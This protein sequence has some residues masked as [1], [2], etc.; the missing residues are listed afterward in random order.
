MKIELRLSWRERLVVTGAD[1]PVCAHAGEDVT[2]SCSVDTHVNVTELQ[3]KWIKTDDDGDILVLLYD[4]G[5]NRPESQDERYSRRAEFY[6]EEIPKGNFSVKLRK[7][8][9]EDKGEFRCEVHSDTDSASTTARIAA[10]GYSSLHWLIL[11]L[12][13]T[14]T[15][16]VLLTGA[17][18][19]GHYI[20]KSKSKQALLSHW[21]HV[22]VPPIMVSS[23]FILW[24]VTEGSTEEAAICTVISLLNILVLFNMNPY[25]LYPGL[26]LRIIYLARTI[27]STII[28]M[29]VCTAPVIEFLKR[30]STTTAGKVTLGVF[31]GAFI[32]MMI[33]MAFIQFIFFRYIYSLSWR[34]T[35]GKLKKTQ[36][37]ISV[38]LIIMVLV[39]I[40]VGVFLA[41]HFSG[42]AET[43]EFLTIFSVSM[44][45]L[46]IPFVGLVILLILYLRSPAEIKERVFL[47]IF[48]LFRS[49]NMM[50]N[51]QILTFY[52]Q[53]IAWMQV[54]FLLGYF[55]PIAVASLGMCAC[56]IA[57]IF[58]HSF[59]HFYLA[60]KILLGIFF[61]LH[62][63][64][65]F[66]YL[67]LILENDK[68]RPAKMCEF[69]FIYIL[70]V[71]N[72]VRSCRTEYLA[73][74]RKYV[75]F[76]G[77][78]G[79]PLVNS[80]A[81]AVALKFK[82][83]TGKPPLDL[84]LIVLISGSVFLFSWLVIQM[85][86]NYLAR[87]V[88]IKEAFT[89]IKDPEPDQPELIQERLL[90]LRHTDEC[91]WE[92]QAYRALWR[93]TRPHCHTMRKVLKHM[94]H[95]QA[96][97]SCQV[98][99][100]ASTCRIISH[101][102]NCTE[103][104]CPICL[105]LKNEGY[106]WHYNEMDDWSDSSDSCVSNA[107]EGSRDNEETVALSPTDPNGPNTE[108]VNRGTR[109]L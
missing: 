56:F 61:I 16:A 102:E 38:F 98:K 77:A 103:H 85:Y 10:L 5:E 55:V 69:L 6:T 48:G 18:S 32:L 96:G 31:V 23:A 22:T 11:G 12:C 9:T 84:R 62:L 43:R 58:L 99:H 24:G 72:N 1:E 70:T 27:G 80:V 101:S 93:C 20:R 82:A 47:R 39:T 81:L 26:Q 78:F 21:S 63:I 83:D 87:K 97:T 75:Y 76:S 15:P 92:K 14:V 90:L 19:V 36:W 107:E 28:I 106:R 49:L 95:C 57:K 7:V 66:L 46:L 29:A 86:A 34:E 45:A 4:D 53:L 64:F 40:G 59:R 54:T 13:I 41:K 3:L 25:G 108:E 30:Y 17:L 67:S 37:A 109:A 71:T 91:Q 60:Q 89:Q 50:F 79:L 94:T 42:R 88:I 8:R 100:C 74:P 35:Q 51:M 73:K 2:L 44:I 52:M 105:P 65:S 68:G 33:V 104:D